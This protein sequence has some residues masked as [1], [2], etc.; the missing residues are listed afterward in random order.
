[1]T[2]IL[3]AQCASQHTG[4][5]GNARKMTF[6]NRTSSKIRV[7]DKVH[8][9]KCFTFYDYRIKTLRVCKKFV[10]VGTDWDTLR[11]RV[12]L[13]MVNERHKHVT[14]RRLRK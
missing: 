14:Q 8:A 2:N 12:D 7:I 5:L 13:N 1:M 9:E 4:L 3:E 6:F 10:N 11:K